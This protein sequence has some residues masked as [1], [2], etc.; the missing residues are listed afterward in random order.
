[1]E[2]RQWKSISWRS[3]GGGM[4]HGGEKVEVNFIIEVKW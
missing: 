1:M 2:F 4:L 3:D